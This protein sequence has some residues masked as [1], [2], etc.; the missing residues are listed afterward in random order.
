MNLHEA[1]PA[2]D[3]ASLAVAFGRS[4]LFPDGLDAPGWGAIA[5]AALAFAAL[6][7]TRLDVLWVIGGGALLGLAL[8]FA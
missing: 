2:D 5:I 7:W 1:R 3:T 4:V 6:H 8:G